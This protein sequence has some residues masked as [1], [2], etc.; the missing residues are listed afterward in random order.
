MP[1]LYR[2]LGDL[3]AR[4]RTRLGYSAAGATTGVNQELLNNFLQGAQELLYWT[5]DWARLRRYTD[6]TIGPNQ[7]LSDYP[8]TAHPDRIKAIS[9]QRNTVWSP[10]LKKGITAQMYTT[11][12]TVSWPQRWEPYDQIETWPKADVSYPIRIFFVRTLLRF[13]EDDDRATL[14]DSIIFLHALADAKAHYK[15][16]DS[17]NYAE[18]RDALIVRLK[19][20]SWGKDVFS[21]YDFDEEQQLV[22]PVVV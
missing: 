11:Q 17:E 20:K 19:A 12:A 4:L 9:I 5:H 21:P 7:Y 3:R 8:P 18:Q 16:K 14:D 13:E 6:S 15:H 10:P 2:T 22:K 1:A